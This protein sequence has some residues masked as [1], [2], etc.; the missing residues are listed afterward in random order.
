MNFIQVVEQNFES[1]VRFH[2]VPETD[3]F[4]A[5][6]SALAR[7]L[8]FRNPSDALS[9]NVFA[10]YRFKIPVGVG[11]PSWYLSEP[12]IYQLIFASK[13]P[14]AVEF[15]KWVFEDVLPKLRASGYY[16]APTAT[17]E[18]LEQMRSEIALL[19]QQR[20]EAQ[21][22]PN[23]GPSLERMSFTEFLRCIDFSPNGAKIA[24]VRH[25][26]DWLDLMSKLFFVTAESPK[27]SI[28][29]KRVPALDRDEFL[30][31]MSKLA[32]DKLVC[33]IEDS[34]LDLF[35]CPSLFDLVPS[36]Q[37][38]SR[39]C[40]LSQRLTAP[41]KRRQKKAY[42][43]QWDYVDQGETQ[44]KQKGSYALG[45]VWGIWFCCFLVPA[46]TPRRNRDGQYPKNA[47]FWD[48]RKLHNVLSPVWDSLPSTIK[49]LSIPKALGR[50]SVY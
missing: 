39:D 43:S 27:G 47:P 21:I 12:G 11:Q 46:T 44:S 2:Y 48:R 7:A 32:E 5:H 20:F 23:L 1:K 6:G 14:K 36:I 8:M 19:Q 9:R 3:K 37:D 24:F 35:P 18:Q 50:A 15:Q 41:A 26:E 42:W 45:W 4:Y 33:T 28:T 22:C 49:A 40:I 30:A 34:S 16:V 31:A 17:S 29:V 38:I 25:E 13:H 10:E